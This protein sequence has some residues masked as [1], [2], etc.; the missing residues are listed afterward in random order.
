LGDKKE[1]SKMFVE[2]QNKG[3]SSSLLRPALHVTQYPW[4]VFD[5]FE[6]VNVDTLDHVV[7]QNNL[8]KSI[9]MINMDVQGFELNVLYGAI[10]TLE[11][12]DY[13]YTEV[14]RAELY[15]GGARVEGLDSFLSGFDRVE[16]EWVGETWG[17]ALYIRKNKKE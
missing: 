14:N 15:E 1:R 12:I 11:Q 17:D 3:M 6:F 9:N 7:Q 13:I 5:N 8:S 4:I 10:K 16:T 2:A